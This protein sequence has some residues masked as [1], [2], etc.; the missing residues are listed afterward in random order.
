MG[1]ETRFAA[2]PADWRVILTDVRKST[3]ALSEGKHQLVNLVATGSIIAALNIAHQAGISLPFFFG[4]DGATLL[5]PPSLAERIEQ[6]L[7]VH[8]ANTRANFALDLRVGSLELAEVYRQG[9]RLQIAKVD[10]NQGLVVPV[11][12]GAGLPLVERIIKREDYVPPS[13]LS[14][15]ALDLNGMECRWDSIRPPDNTQEVVCLLVVA[16]EDK[17]QSA[18][19]SHVLAQLDL[20]YGPLATRSPVALSRLK[21]KATLGKIN[22]EMRAK[23]GRFDIR[24]LLENW[25]CTL[26]GGPYFKFN[27]E[28]AKYLRNLVKWSDTLMIDGRINTIMC[29]T[30]AQR[31]ALVETLQRLEDRADIRFGLHVSQASVISCYVRDRRNQHIHFVDGLGGGYTQAASMLKAKIAR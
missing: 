27:R 8:R 13:T 7:L 31:H 30:A 14:N 18:V 9:A 29:G 15:A 2:M 4:G 19:F 12:L 17:R 25:L 22:T 21:L 10:I 11:T 20:I 28:G 5:V 26:I 6:A 24:Y 1:D 3:Q 23:L 16:Q